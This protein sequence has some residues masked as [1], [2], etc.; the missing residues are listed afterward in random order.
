MRTS[1]YPFICAV[2]LLMMPVGFL[3][4]QTDTTDGSYGDDELRDLNERIHVLEAR[5]AE[6]IER[7]LGSLRAQLRDAKRLEQSRLGQSRGA[8][9]DELPS[10]KMAERAANGQSWRYRYHQGRWWYWRPSNS[11]AAYDQERW[12]PYQARAVGRYY[13]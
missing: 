8:K 1:C 12:V 4:A 9:K 11:W 3:A 10:K 13:R 5:Q 2:G 7:E 6:R